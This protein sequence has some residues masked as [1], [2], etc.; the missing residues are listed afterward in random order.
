MNLISN[1]I[2]NGINSQVERLDFNVNVIMK[3]S[4]FYMALLARYQK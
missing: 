1:I 3:L 4:Y 2:D